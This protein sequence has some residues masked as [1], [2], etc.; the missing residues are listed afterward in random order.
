[1]SALPG[2]TRFPRHTHISDVVARDVA[3]FANRDQFPKCPAWG[4]FLGALPLGF[5]RISISGN[6]PQSG[7]PLFRLLGSGDCLSLLG[8]PGM[9]NL[10]P[11]SRMCPVLGMIP[12]E[13]VILLIDLNLSFSNASTE[14]RIYK[15]LRDHQKQVIAEHWSTKTEIE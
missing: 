14:L 2:L 9:V 4:F 1:M 15:A 3:K 5:A 13:S 12:I 10:L 7:S 11:G 8:K 6:L